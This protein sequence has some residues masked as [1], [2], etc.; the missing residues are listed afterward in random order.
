MC[1]SG[2]GKL[3]DNN[4]VDLIEVDDLGELGDPISGISVGSAE[5][6]KKDILGRWVYEGASEF[7]TSLFDVE[8]IEPLAGRVYVGCCGMLAQVE[9]F[10]EAHAG[11]T[12]R[13]HVCGLNSTTPMVTVRWLWLHPV[14]SAS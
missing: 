13:H 3:I 12:R 10:V 1:V 8:V 7:H 11:P 6:R 4:A 14:S 5:R 2:S 9:G